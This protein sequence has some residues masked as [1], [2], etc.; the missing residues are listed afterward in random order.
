MVV[1]FYCRII[2]SLSFRW[3]GQMLLLL[4]T[5]MIVVTMAAML[6]PCAAHIKNSRRS[7]LW[8]KSST[9]LMSQMSQAKTL[10]PTRAVR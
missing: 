8:V 1:S 7:A 9:L 5:R 10:M 6:T 2:V 3:Y 4:R